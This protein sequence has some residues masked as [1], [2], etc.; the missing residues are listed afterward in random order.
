MPKNQ[1]ADLPRQRGDAVVISTPE[2][3]ARVLKCS[4]RD[5]RLSMSRSSIETG[6]KREQPR[7]ASLIA[8]S[9]QPESSCALR[10]GSHIQTR[11]CLQWVLVLKRL[12]SEGSRVLLAGM[13]SGRSQ[14][15][16]GIP[17]SDSGGFM[18]HTTT[19]REAGTEVQSWV[20]QPFPDSYTSSGQLVVPSPP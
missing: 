4:I 9:H 16:N 17:Y 14:G 6:P 2:D 7:G 8:S 5:L 18:S 1:I 19:Q 13:E 20:H 15:M 10:V 3:L 12:Q 11:S